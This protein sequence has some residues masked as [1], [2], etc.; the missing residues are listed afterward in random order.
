MVGK[1]DENGVYKCGCRLM[2]DPFAG[3]KTLVMCDTHFKAW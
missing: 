3:Y 1:P 2:L